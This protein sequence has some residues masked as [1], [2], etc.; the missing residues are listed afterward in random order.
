MSNHIPRMTFSSAGELMTEKL[1]K[2]STISSAQ[3]ASKKMRDKNVSSLIVIEVN[4]KKPM[5]IVTERDLVR[6]ACVRDIGTGNVPI[7]DIMSTLP[8][9]TVD[10]KSS[11]E[12][13][14]NTMI[15]NKVRHLLVIDDNDINNIVGIITPTDFVGYLK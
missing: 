9:V 13:A 14:A 12:V 3:E 15:Q 2:I 4:N 1:E 11:V 10:S 7:K 5:G 8:L 6:K